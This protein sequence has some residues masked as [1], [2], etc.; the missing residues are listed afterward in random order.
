MTEPV[1]P[2]DW[3]RHYAAQREQHTGRFACTG[4]CTRGV[5]G[6][7]AGPKA[8]G[9]CCECRLTCDGP[10]PATVPPVRHTA[11]TITDND[12][13]Q[14][15]ARVDFYEAAA[16]RMRDRAEVATVRQTRAEQRAEQA[17]ADRDRWQAGLETAEVQ[18][19]H[20]RRTLDRVRAECDRIEAAVRDNPTSPDLTGG[21]LACL[22]HIRAALDDPK[23][24]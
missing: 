2:I 7:S 6:A 18:L 22:R 10:E 16:A 17:E 3:A 15:Y 23:E 12:L 13:D 8:C 20:H 21:Y 14:L 19:E 5:C 11:D 24:K 1:A 9:T 4:P